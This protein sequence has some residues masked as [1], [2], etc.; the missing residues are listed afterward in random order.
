MNSA[1]LRTVRAVAPEGV[2]Y[3]LYDGVGHLP[4]FNPDDDRDPL[5]SSV[6]RLRAAVHR[7]DAILFS[8][9][10]YA[11]ALPGA[12]KNLLEWLIGDDQH[13]SIYEKPVAW[14]NASPRGATLAHE[15]LRTVVAYAKATVVEAACADVPITAGALGEDGLVSDRAL[16]EKLRRVAQ[17]LSGFACSSLVAGT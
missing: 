12:L 2:T 1:V 9:P 4:L 16:R 8:T 17:T 14:I 13:R 10:E 5:P 11:G 3:E 7:S 6:T 15:S